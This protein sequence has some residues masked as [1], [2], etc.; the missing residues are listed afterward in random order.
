MTQEPGVEDSGE[1]VGD[2]PAVEAP[3]T[4]GTGAPATAGEPH[5]QTPLASDGAGEDEDGD[6]Q[7]EDGEGDD[8]GED[9]ED[10]SVREV[11]HRLAATTI[12]EEMEVDE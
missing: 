7:M 4:Q 1:S 5:Q 8:E 12:G 2:D 11:R 3:H 10:G 6:V 9:D